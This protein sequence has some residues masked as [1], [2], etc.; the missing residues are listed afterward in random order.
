LGKVN[1]KGIREIIPIGY[2]Y[3][4]PLSDTPIGYP[5]RIPLSDTP[6]RYPYQGQKTQ[7]IKAIGYLIR[8]SAFGL[9][10]DYKAFADFSRFSVAVSVAVFPSGP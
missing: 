4:I 1:Q 3:P 6:I 10:K 9:Y 8:W 7:K 5:Y 2:P